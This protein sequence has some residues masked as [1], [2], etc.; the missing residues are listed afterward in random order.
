MSFF[1]L[2]T[3]FRIILLAYLMNGKDDYMGSFCGRCR[4]PVEDGEL[5]CP[6]CG[7]EINWDNSHPVPPPPQRQYQQQQYAPFPSEPV[8]F[9]QAPLLNTWK[10]SVGFSVLG[11][12]VGFPFMVVLMILIAILPAFGIYFLTGIDPQAIIPLLAPSIFYVLEIVYAAVFYPS[13]FTEK[14]KL[15]SSRIISLLNLVFGFVIFGVLWNSNLTKKNK[16]ISYIVLIVGTAL[17]LAQMLFGILLS[18][19]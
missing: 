2:L 13:Y 9:E 11:V 15:K 7:A 1:M 14:P 10:T 17:M 19:V 5:H 6:E 16:G 12:L 8:G 3:A 18:M 4:A